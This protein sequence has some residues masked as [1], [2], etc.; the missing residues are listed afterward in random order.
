META[1]CKLKERMSKSDLILP[2]VSFA[3][4]S[5]YLNEIVIIFS[6]ADGWEIP[7]QID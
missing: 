5:I 3:V 2:F 7:G 6:G 1:L 4:V